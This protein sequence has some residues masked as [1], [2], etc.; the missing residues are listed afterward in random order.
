[1]N[2]D[3]LI[4]RAGLSVEAIRRSHVFTGWQGHSPA[5]VATSAQRTRLLYFTGD[6]TRAAPTD[7]EGTVA[8]ETRRDQ[9]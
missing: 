4:G 9:A 6:P 2:P 1:M 8:N 5:L 7:S 3:V